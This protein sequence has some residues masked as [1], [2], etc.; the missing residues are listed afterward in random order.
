VVVGDPRQLEPIVAL[1]HG[2]QEGLRGP[3][4]VDPRWVPGR[5]SAQRLAD[6]VSPVGTADDAGGEPLWVGVPLTLHR[7]CE[8]PMFGIVNAMAYG[9]RM[10]NGT[11]PRPPLAL[12]PSAWLDVPGDGAEGHWVPA[13]GERLDGVLAYLDHRGHDLRQVLV[14]SPFRDVAR[15]LRAHARRWPGITAGTVHTAQGR[16]A[17]IVILVLGGEPGGDGA[18]RWATRRP[19]LLNVAVSRARRR[20]WV[21]GDLAA[22]SRHPHAATIAERLPAKR[23]PAR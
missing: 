15:A 10:I 4:G 5:T 11:P 8:E 17:D 13:Q 20:L 9:G 19:N 3:H 6:R 18:R 22:W 2:T 7:R 14:V 23:S 16:E 1:P 12:P 21:I